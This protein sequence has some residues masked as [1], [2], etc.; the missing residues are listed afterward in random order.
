MHTHRSQKSR[1]GT[2][3]QLLRY[4]TLPALCCVLMSGCLRQ[5][6]N[7]EPLPEFE[8]PEAWAGA[9]LAGDG[10]S[11]WCSD[12]G[13]PR[14]AAL[15]D[16]AFSDNLQLSAALAR[17]DRAEAAAR[18]AGAARFPSLMADFQVG[19]R[20]SSAIGFPSFGGPAPEPFETTTWSLSLPVSY[21]VDMFGRVGLG[22]RAALHDAVALQD[23]V[24]TIALTIA[25]Q[26]AELWFAMSEAQ[27][28][29]DVVDEQI[30]TSEE[31]L[32]LVTLRFDHGLAGALDVQQQR[33]QIATLQSRRVLADNRV[34]Q[35][36]QQLALLVGAIPGQF[37][38]ETSGE[39]PDLP[40][41]IEVGVPADLLTQRPDVRAAQRRVVAADTRVSQ[42]IAQR[43][44]ALRLSAGLNFQSLNLADLF[45]EI[46]WS[47]GASLSGALF[48]GGAGA[49]GVDAADAALAESLANFGQTLLVA[50]QEVESALL[51]EDIQRQ[52]LETLE[53]E[54]ELARTSYEQARY[55]FLNG[56][57]DTTYLR[58]LSAQQS[59][60]ALEQTRVSARRE[61]LSQRV[62]LCRAVGGSWT[63]EALERARE[64]NE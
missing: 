59:L 34:A 6:I 46:L 40:P 10:V 49:A 8:L 56:M 33:Q 14:L 21:E 57:E 18:Q 44:P 15:I 11:E 1:I 24:E 55:R 41:M 16:Q 23:D 9:T 53:A 27:S 20:R 19:R 12:F 39:L 60:H 2:G 30:A 45:K 61:A 26:I 17:V 3:G 35:A 4:A 22:R 62:Q 31:L 25:A 64:E 37:E 29:V 54:T 13:D 63:A 28:V 32:D 52:Y 50:I 38:A 58:V 42:A 51:N 7:D 5:R 47:V 43:L 36:M 48:D